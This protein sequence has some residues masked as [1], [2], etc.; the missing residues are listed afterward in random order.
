MQVPR[1]KPDDKD[2]VYPYCRHEVY[3]EDGID[4]I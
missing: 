4:K 2:Y 1:L 3:G